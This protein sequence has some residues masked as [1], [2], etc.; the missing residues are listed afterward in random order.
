MSLESVA[1][2]RRKRIV[3]HVIG[4]FETAIDA[5]A[6]GSAVEKIV[7]ERL[8]NI[9][10]RQYIGAT[11]MKFAI[12]PSYTGKTLLKT[13]FLEVP[14]D[15]AAVRICLDIDLCCHQNK[16]T[17]MDQVIREKPQAQIIGG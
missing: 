16:K 2:R 8:G 13:T 3:E 10:F 11:E 1:E 9:K 14:G 15:E 4:E 7:K 6:F 5:I 17:I 12:P